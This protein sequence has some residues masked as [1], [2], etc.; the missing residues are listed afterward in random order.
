MLNI[1]QQITSQGRLDSYSTAIY[2]EVWT[3]EKTISLINALNATFDILFTLNAVRTVDRFG[4]C[5]LTIIGAFGISLCT[6][7]VAIV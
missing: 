3:S 7:L 1:A 5:W 6:M 4:R 2:K